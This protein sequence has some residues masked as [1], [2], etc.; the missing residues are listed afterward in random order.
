[1]NNLTPTEVGVLND[2]STLRNRSVALGGMLDVIVKSLKTAGTPV[3]AVN[4][5]MVL[6]LSGA[7]VDGETLTI[8]NP[9]VAGSDVYE[10]LADE[11]QTKTNSSNKAVDITDYAA[12]ATVNLTVDTQPTSGDK[13]TI[14]SK[15][16]TFVP[17]GTD[18]AD[19]E[20]SVGTDLASAKLAIVAAINGTDEFNEPHPLV[21]AAAFAGDVCAITALV[22]G[23]S[24]NSIV[25]TET[26][27]AGTNVFSAA[28][29]GSGDDCS[30]SEAVTA[31]V[32]AITALDTQGVGAA[33]GTGDT[34]DLTADTAGEAGNDISL[35]TTMTNGSF[36]DDAEALAGGV[37][38][39]VGS[40]HKVMVDSSYLYVCVAENTVAGKNWRRISVGTA[41]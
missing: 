14:G 15:V 24:G 21:S 7:V 31:L 26:F 1:M 25:S 39:T 22:G 16:Y 34:I 12:K 29:L 9:L 2:L 35:A 19:G 20:V 3:N 28:T 10:F 4:A 27:T 8:N 30:A 11:A 13:M 41:Y 32:A 5:A 6:T 18:T 17:D 23:T 33:D 37:N 38:G 36:T 40:I